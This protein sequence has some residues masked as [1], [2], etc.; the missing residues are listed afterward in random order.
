MMLT[1]PVGQEF[2]KSTVRMALSCSVMS[3]ASAGMA[4]VAGPG[5]AESKR[6]TSNMAVLHPLAWPLGR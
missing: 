6:V 4:P 2:G 3:G 5:T 1:D